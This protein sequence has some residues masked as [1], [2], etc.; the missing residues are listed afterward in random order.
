MM[1]NTPLVV[2]AG[3]RHHANGDVGRVAAVKRQRLMMRANRVAPAIAIDVWPL[4]KLAVRPIVRR[5][6]KRRRQPGLFR[7]LEG[8]GARGPQYGG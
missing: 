1:R 5:G 4:M 8:M 2:A 3:Y 6:R 7:S